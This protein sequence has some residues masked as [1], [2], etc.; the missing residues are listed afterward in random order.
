M[1]FDVLCCS[2]VLYTLR[3]S[4]C[5][6]RA[7]SKLEGRR[8]NVRLLPLFVKQSGH[9]L[10]TAMRVPSVTPFRSRVD[11]KLR[12]KI[13]RYFIYFPATCHCVCKGP[14][15]SQSPVTLA[16]WEGNGGGGG[17]GICRA[18]AGSLYLIQYA[19]YMNYITVHI[20]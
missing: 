10:G 14:V 6:M 18:P 19:L 1:G 15:I 7:F 8:L 11:D 3:F 2:I 13:N 12:M 20:V 9:Y 4:S 5:H 17:V 16:S